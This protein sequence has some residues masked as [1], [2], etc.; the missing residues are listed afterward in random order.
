MSLNEYNPSEIEGKW[1][2]EWLKSAIFTPSLDD[3]REPFVVV[4]PPPNVTGSLHIGHALNMTLQDISVRYKRMRGFNTL[5]LPGFDHA[6]IAT[7]WVVTKQLEK[8]GINKFELGREKFVEKVWEWVPVARDTIKKQIETIGASC[9][10]TRQ[11]FTLDEGFARA[12]REAFSKLFKEGLIF[13]APYIVNWDPKDRTAISDLEVEYKEEKGNLWYIR[14]PVVDENGK[15]TG[16]YIVVATTRPETMLGDTAVAVHPEDER[17]KNLIGKKVKLPLAP[18]KRLAW[19][20]KEVSNLIPVVPDDYVDP[21]YGTGAVKITPAHD[22]NDFEVGKRHDLPMVIVMDESAVMN[23]NAGKYRGLDRYEAREQIVKDL[24]DMGLLEKVEEI[25]HNVGHSQRSGAVVEPYL[26]VQW[27]VNTKE[28]AKDAIKVVENGDIRFIP[29]NWKK[30][31]LNWMYD[32]RDWCISRQIW[33]GHRIPVWECKKC[34]QYNVF[35]DDIFEN[36]AQKVIFNMYGDTR[37]GQIFSSEEVKTY[38]YGKNFNQ[39]DKTNLQFYEQFV[40]N[41]EIPELKKEE[42]LKEFL[43]KNYIKVPVMNP[44]EIEDS[45]KIGFVPHAVFFLY[46]NGFIGKTFDENDVF[47]AYQKNK[48]IIRYIYDQGLNGIKKEDILEDKD[49]LKKWLFDHAYGNCK[50]G[51]IFFSETQERFSIIEEHIKELRY[52]IELRCEKCGSYNLKQEEDVLDTWFSS[53]L[54]PF[55][56]LGWPEETKDLQKFYPTSLLVTGFDIIFFWV[57]RMIMMGMHFMKEKPFGDVYIHALVRDEKGEKMS[58]TKGNVIDPL[59]M[60]KKYGADSLRF[61]LA[62]LAAQGRDIRLSEKRIEGYKHFANKIWNASR[63][64]LMNF[65]NNRGKVFKEISALKL[66]YDD[67]WILTRLQEV[68]KSSEKAL[69]EYR[70]NDY[71]N[72]LYDFFWHEYCDWYL[73]F[74]KE[75][76][77]KGSDEEKA[78]ALSTLIYVLDKSMRMLHPVMPFLTE[79]IWQKLPF[80]DSEYL[81]VAQYPEY[82]EGLVFE[83]EKQLIEDLKEMIV[84]IRNVRA[85]FGIEPSRRLNV[86]IKPSDEEFE[87]VIKNMEPSIKLL[88]KIENLEITA[89]RPPNTVVAVSKRAES[90]IDIAG[91]IDIEKE[92][93]RQEKILKDIQKSISISEKKLSNENFVKKA[94]SHVVEKE[95]QLYKELKEKEEKVKKIIESLKEVQTS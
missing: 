67:K 23:E 69:E 83:K 70:Y 13:K 31:Y 63:F 54:W 11:R 18:E 55:G 26:S 81:P 49:K 47:E 6:G 62:A 77:Y 33:W 93:K 15:E 42:D 25:I 78:A 52:F 39:P 65:E 73:E 53:A 36:T 29:E 64:V 22:P 74:S 66:S 80:K 8:E 88:A 34:G 71:A 89:E 60:V 12:V 2:K 50:N 79:E 76:I 10:W 51:R 59:D 43:D 95:K 24:E 4:M 45:K 56:T 90:Y 35:S 87:S 94:P 37:I 44:E 7:Q 86:Y 57:A 9:D 92:L 28:L 17:Y 30:T 20:G 5:W 19:D 40:F 68:I 3:Q 1:Y 72:G 75:R 32:I 48:E 16:E 82:E 58:K 85:D 84:S 38:L 61:T 41:R 46:T 27:F 14:Y 21:E 91:T